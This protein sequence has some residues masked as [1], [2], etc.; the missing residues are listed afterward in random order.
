VSTP[1]LSIY[2]PTFKTT[3]GQLA[4]PQGLASALWS[5]DLQHTPRKDFVQVVIAE[6]AVRG[7]SGVGGMFAQVPEHAARV[8]GDYV[9]W[10]CDDDVL[11]DDSVVTRLF[12]A[13]EEAHRPDVLVVSTIKGHFGRLPFHGFGPPILGAF[14][15]NCLVMKRDVWLAHVSDWAAGY[16][17]DYAAA[18][19]MWNAGRRFV[20]RTDLL[21][22]KGAISQGQPEAA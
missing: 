15:L 8:Q 17:G 21:F 2:L 9:V 7:G 16:E 18:I 1:F 14:D 4:R 6:D 19:A 3:D 10:L 5:I 13:V 20:Y 22:S 11:A 12:A